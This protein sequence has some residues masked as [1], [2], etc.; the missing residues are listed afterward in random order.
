MNKEHWF[1]MRERAE[2][3]RKQEAWDKVKEVVSWIALVTIVV[4]LLV[5]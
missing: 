3:K 1:T 2:M 5:A 4:Y